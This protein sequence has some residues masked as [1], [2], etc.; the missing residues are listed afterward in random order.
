MLTIAAVILLATS[1]IT[2]YSVLTNK[3]EPTEAELIKVA[4][5]GDSITQGSGYPYDLWQLLGSSGQFTI[6]DY[7]QAPSGSPNCNVSYAVGNFGAG[8]TMVTLKSETPYMNTT[9]FQNALDYQPDIV[10]IMLGTNDAQPGV[11]Q[12]NAS[13][14]D[15][16]KALIQAFQTLASHPKIWIALPPP[17][18]DS[19]GGKTSPEWL[20]QNVIPNIRQAANETNIPII[21]VHSALA[22]YASDFPDGI[23]P[24]NTAAKLIADKIFNEITA[25]K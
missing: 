23:H 22:G 20:E 2:V 25:Q 5:V 19:Q 13:F 12:Y 17:I 10:I 15:D 18:F 7:T 21:D 6:A 14:V 9:T 8:G 16:Y 24:N 4:C 3:N 1:A 11:H